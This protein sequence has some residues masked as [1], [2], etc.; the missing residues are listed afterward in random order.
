MHQLTLLPPLALARLA[1]LST[2][3]RVSLSTGRSGVTPPDRREIQADRGR[4]ADLDMRVPTVLAIATLSGPL[5]MDARGRVVR[6]GSVGDG[7][8][9]CG[10]RA[11]GTEVLATDRDLVWVVYVRAGR[12]SL[13][14]AL[15]VF[16]SRRRGCP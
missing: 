3:P 8:G 4:I 11:G 15:K 12:S 9:L 5:E 10:M 6:V 7:A 16:R 14:G 13:T 2:L 1:I